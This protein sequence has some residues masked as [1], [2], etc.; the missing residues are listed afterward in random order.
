MTVISPPRKQLQPS[1][2]HQADP[3]PR[4]SLPVG[5]TLMARG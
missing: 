1:H 2:G 4:P 5:S 3:A